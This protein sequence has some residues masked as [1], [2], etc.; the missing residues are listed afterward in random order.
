[1]AIDAILYLVI[2]PMSYIPT[3]AGSGANQPVVIDLTTP[4]EHILADL[5]VPSG[6]MLTIE[7][8]GGGGGG[9]GS[10]V[11]ASPGGGGGGGG[12]YFM[13]QC[14]LSELGANPSLNVA[15]VVAGGAANTV[16]VDGADTYL[17]ND[18]DNLIGA[19]GG[20]HGVAVAG[21][22]GAGGTVNVGIYT[23]TIITKVAGTAGTTATTAAGGK[24]G[25]SVGPALATGGAGG[26]GTSGAG[27]AGAAGGGGGGGGAATVGIGGGGGR[28]WGRISFPVGG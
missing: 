23:G 27:A 2:D 24:G 18:D 15:D 19:G 16:G 20:H 28:G 12:A 4:G 14:L 25:N 3:A 8:N 26:T 21:V 13:I 5:G 6:V 7:G 22:G 17:V 1:M 11:G 9:A 10:P